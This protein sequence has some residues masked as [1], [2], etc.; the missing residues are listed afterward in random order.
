MNYTRQKSRPEA[1][2]PAP[3]R[4]IYVPGA[5][6]ADGEPRVALEVPPRAGAAS[7]RTALIVFGS[8][9]LA[10]SAK[11]AMEAGR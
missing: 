9:A 10:L 4:V 3:V 11:R 2:H 6:D 8:M 5:L 1:Q 7:R